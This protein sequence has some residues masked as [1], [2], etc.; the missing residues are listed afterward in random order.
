[1]SPPTAEIVREAS[2]EVVDAVV[3]LM[4]QLTTRYRGDSSGIRDL[5][6][7]DNAELLIARDES[8]AIVATATVSWYPTAAGRLARLETV[9]VD[10]ARRR[11]GA[12]SAVMALAER[13]AAQNGAR[14]MQLSTGPSREA[15]RNFY[16]RIGFS[17]HPA[18]A[19]SKDVDLAGSR[20]GNVDR[21]L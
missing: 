14:W 20:L 2:G 15:A 18:V 9:V 13:I 10:E 1:M 7:S 6:A 4:S 5:V 16:S 17:G 8:G 11:S 3:R 21:T 12:G 19:F